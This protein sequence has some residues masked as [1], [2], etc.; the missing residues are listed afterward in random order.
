[1]TP[2]V[3]PENYH[4]LRL[5]AIDPGLNNNGYALIQ[6]DTKL[7]QI[8]SIE[9][10]SIATDKLPDPWWVNHNI[11]PERLVKINK[12][13]STFEQLAVATQPHVVVCESPF[14]NPTRPNAFKALVEAMSAIQ[15]GIVKANPF[16]QFF[17]IAPQ[18]MKAYLKAIKKDS[19]KDYVRERVMS[20][21]DIQPFLIDVIDE[22]SEHAVDAVGV[23]Y[24][25]LKI[26]GE[27]L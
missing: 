13:E 16:L 18:Q 5:L 8:I 24:A 9:A 21:P 11:H 7:K 20:T 6:V 4:V 22:L 10:H 15:I 17:F 2:L 23:G 26:T 12:I 19:T 3:V 25:Y 27:L 1:M 14:F